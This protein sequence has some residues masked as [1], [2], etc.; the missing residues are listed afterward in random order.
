VLAGGRVCEIPDLETVPEPA[1]SC[2]A[3]RALGWR[4]RAA[5]QLVARGERAGVL[6]V[7]WETSHQMDDRER[8]LLDVLAQHAALS[9]TNAR[10]FDENQRQRNELERLRRQLA[11]CQAARNV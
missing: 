6:Y 3:A 9:L 7:A 11:E 8:T 10:S 5:Q 4:A 2:R 1:T